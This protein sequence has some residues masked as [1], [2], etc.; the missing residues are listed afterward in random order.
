M[1]LDAPAA[2][3]RSMNFLPA[4]SS[5]SNPFAKPVINTLPFDLFQII[6]TIVC[7]EGDGLAVSLSHVCR[8]WRS[9]ALS[10]PFLWN[11]LEFTK[12]APNWEMLDAKLKRSGQAP[13]DVYLAEATFVKSGMPH[14][15]RI[16]RMIVP[17]ISR[18]RTLQM[19]DVPHKIR[20]VLLDQ[21]RG[22]TVPVLERVEV[23]QGNKYERPFKC[24]IKSTS[25]HWDPRR[26][27]DGARNLRHLEWTIPGTE[28]HLLPP[29]Q[30]LLTL[31]IGEDTLQLLPEP[32]IELVLS[33]LSAIPT[34][35]ELTVYND[36]DVSP[37]L[38]AFPASL[39]HLVRPPVT[40]PSLQLLGVFGLQAI[41]IAILQSLILPNLQTFGKPHWQTNLHVMCCTFIAQTRPF[42]KLRSIIL[43]GDGNF[44]DEHISLD[45]ISRYMPNLPSA[46]SNLQKLVVLTFISVHFGGNN[47]W[48]PNLGNCCPHLKR[49]TMMHCIGYTVSAIRGIVEMRLQG[50]GIVPLEELRVDPLWSEPETEPTA[51]DIAW[52]SSVLRYNRN[53]RSWYDLS[54]YDV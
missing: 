52:F 51:E 46:V 53:D 18:W 16:M 27:F 38:T 10:M 49:L 20:R 34:L 28:S 35:Q 32:V 26:I 2:V 21:L 12:C 14:L 15:R 23:V 13:L 25:P 48:L 24:R 37:E 47:R 36:P 43:D 54:D 29:F 19:V 50:G 17:Q 8:L 11:E 31:T 7:E 6:F 22:R 3:A 9:C 40:I 33:I 44:W 30:Q 41:R 4:L 5:A 39:E 45:G 1:E 42:P